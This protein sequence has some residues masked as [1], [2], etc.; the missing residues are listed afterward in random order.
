MICILKD[1]SGLFYKRNRIVYAGLLILTVVVGIGSRT[2][3]IY[4]HPFLAEYLGDVLWA[5]MVYF[6]ICF[7]FKRIS[8]KKAAII[9]LLFSYFIEVSQ[10]YQAD[11]INAIRNT[12]VGALI[13]GHGFLWSDLICY[14][15][16]ILFAVL[17][18]ILLLKRLI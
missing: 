16:G 8:I 6:L 11:W 13:L 12:V 7:F 3:S 15:V 14:T 2:C 9:A 18:D 10:L 17:I 5:S 4:F 1:I